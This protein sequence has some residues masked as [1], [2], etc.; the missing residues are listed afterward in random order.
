MFNGKCDG[1]AMKDETI[2]QLRG[3]LEEA[4]KTALAAVDARAY[5][6]RYPRGKPDR[7]EPTDAEG[8][9]IRLGPT[10]PADLRR[11]RF[12]GPVETLTADE[13]ERSFA[14]E[15]EARNRGEAV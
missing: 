11:S 13:I 5:Q 2:A 1:C 14:A 9:P 15:A 7:P 10:S 12:K 8:N 3:L 4:T 6:I